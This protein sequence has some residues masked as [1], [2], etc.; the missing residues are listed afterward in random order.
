[1]ETESPRKGEGVQA[2]ILSEEKSSSKEREE[3]N[4]ES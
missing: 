4:A 3:D 2:Q 1:M